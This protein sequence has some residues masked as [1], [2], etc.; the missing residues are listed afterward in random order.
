M[1]RS[2]KPGCFTPV[3]TPFQ[4]NQEV[5]YDVLA[6]LVARLARCGQGI[7][8]LGT[9]GEASHLTD[10]ERA[11]VIACA[12]RA[13]DQEGLKD[14]LLMAG[15]G[16]G[17]TFHTIKLCE[18]A[19]AA[20]ADACIVI[21]PAYTGQMLAKDREALKAHYIEVLDKSPLPIFGY[22]FPQITSGIDMDS[23]FINEL[24]EHKN[25]I[26]FKLTCQSMSKGLRVAAYTSTPEY[27]ARHGPF[28]LLP[29]MADYLLPAMI[30]KASG[31]IAGTGNLLPKTIVKLYDLS[32]AGLAGDPARLKEAVELQELVSEA[33]YRLAQ[34][35]VPGIKAILNKNHN[36]EGGYCR[37]PLREFSDAELDNILADPYVK[38]AFEYE[39]AL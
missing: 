37:K 1:S 2:F 8:V 28:L 7:V 10:E 34:I 31:C 29:G 19:K 12:R 6:K 35:S 22:N 24:A 18:Q 16:T 17:S 36:G 9:T 14:A 26:G 25:L 21:S 27:I 4:A 38:K 33:D 3:S 39:N 32:K 13:L 15:T 5:D 30:G 11:G 23:I 20:G